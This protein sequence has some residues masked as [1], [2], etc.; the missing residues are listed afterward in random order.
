MEAQKH[1][2]GNG[3]SWSGKPSLQALTVLAAMGL[4]SN[5]HAAVRYSITDLGT[6]GGTYSHT[7]GIN[8]AGRVA[9]GSET[10]SEEGH[11]FVTVDG[12]MTDLG[13]LG[14]RDSRAEGINDAGQIAADGVI[15]GQHRAVLLTRLRRHF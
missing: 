5:A 11:A 6:L 10:A 14:G 1:A 9:G 8:D 2:I 7:I 4:A 13:T 3:R 15:D 12:V